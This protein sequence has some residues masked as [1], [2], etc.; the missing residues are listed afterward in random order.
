MISWNLGFVLYR[1]ENPGL[2]SEKLDED[3]FKYNLST[4]RSKAFQ[5]TREV[6]ERFRLPVGTYVIIPSTF[7]P[8]YEG[9]FLL[10]TFTET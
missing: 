4:G 8:G 7:E 3:F 5:N 2:A 1:L 10:R 6:T 9:E